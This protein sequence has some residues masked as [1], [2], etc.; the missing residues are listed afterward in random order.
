MHKTRYVGRA[1][2]VPELLSGCRKAPLMALGINP[3][4]PGWWPYRGALNPLFDDYRQYAHYFRYRARQARAEP[5]GL[6]ALRRRRSR[7]AVLGLRARSRRTRNGNREIEVSLARQKMYDGYQDLLEG[8]ADAMGWPKE[9]LTVGEDLAY[10]NMVASPSA[11]WTTK[12]DPKD[13]A[14]PPMTEDERAGIT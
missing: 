4:L 5:G 9:K 8:L 1:P 2:L 10:G 7:H 13:P 12:A 11:K 14:L 3:N 6:Q